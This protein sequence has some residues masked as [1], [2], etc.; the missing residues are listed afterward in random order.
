MLQIY[1]AVRQKDRKMNAV[2]IVSEYN[3]FHLGHLFHV[4]KIRESE[5]ENTVILSALSGD[6]IQRGEPAVFS[7][8]ARAEMAV[9]CGVDLVAE[10]PAVY[11]LRSAEGFAE[12][13]VSILHRL[14]AGVLS[15]GTEMAEKGEAEE[16]AALLLSED[17]EQT[18]RKRIRTSPGESYASMREKCVR[19]LIGE[20]AEI[21]RNP[22]DILAVEYLKSIRKNGYA[23]RFLPVKRIGPAHDTL[24]SGP[25]RS[26][27]EIRGL[28]AEG[29]DISSF[30]PEKVFNILRREIEAGRGPVAIESLEQALLSRLRILTAEDFVCTEDCDEELAERILGAVLTRPGAETIFLAAKSRKYTLAR[31]R[32]VCFCA[33]LGITERMQKQEAPFIRVLAASERGCQWLKELKNAS[34]DVPVLLKPADARRIGEKSGEFMKFL[35]MVHDFYALAYENREDRLCGMDYRE[36]PRI[37]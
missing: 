23:M 36:S 1:G 24:S 30:L 7:K 15:C 20:K 9:R 27:R 6:F 31:V 32:R 12:A 34:P 19:S 2:G 13:G 37:L 14:G 11:S 33:A 10:L 21:L 28:L 4:E 35:S 17:F 5:G 16:I 26:A 29:K 18:L 8:Y 25:V 3:P 22:N